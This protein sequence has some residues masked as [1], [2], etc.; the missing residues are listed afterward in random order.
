VRTLTDSVSRDF[1]IDVGRPS[2]D[3]AVEI[4][5]VLEAVC[6]QKGRDVSTSY[7][8][9]AHDHDRP[10]AVELFEATRKLAH[11]YLDAIRQRCESE[12]RWL[13][14]VEKLNAGC[15]AVGPA[16]YELSWG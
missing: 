6:Y 2:V 8:R 10:V 7:A 13:A 4:E 15:N 12:L 14:N 1:W 11:R 16:I 9:V 5:Y 3:T